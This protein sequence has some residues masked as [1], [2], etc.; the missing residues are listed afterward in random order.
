MNFD[1]VEELQKQYEQFC[2]NCSKAHD[3]TCS[4]ANAKACEE[5]KNEILKK[6]F[7]IKERDA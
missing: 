1:E 7:E 2:N 5:K 6:I 4:G 3:F